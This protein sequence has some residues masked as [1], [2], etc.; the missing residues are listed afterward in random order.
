MQ[1]TLPTGMCDACCLYSTLA[2]HKCCKCG[3]CYLHS[4]HAINKNFHIQKQ[5]IVDMWLRQ[6]KR[7]KLCAPTG[8]AAQRL[9]VCVLE[10]GNGGGVWWWV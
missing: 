2:M 4:T 7:V 10:G 1:I 3:A 8:R 5:A 6:G 9:Q